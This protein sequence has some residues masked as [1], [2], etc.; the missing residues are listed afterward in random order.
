MKRFYKDVSIDERDGVWRV[1]LDGRVLKTQGKASVELPNRALA[2]AVATEWAAQDENIDPPNMFLTRLAFAAIDGVKANRQRVA[3]HALSFGRTDLLCY[4]AEQPEEL[5]AR[6]AA[7]WNPLLDWVAERYGVRL[8]VATGIAF[9]EQS[10]EAL[11]ALERAIAGTDDFTL[12]AL[13]T[14]ATITGSLVLALALIEEHIDAE[15]AFAAATLDET[16]QSEKWGLDT[17]AQ[18]RLNRLSAELS[19]A[20]QFAAFLP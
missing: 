8:S 1:L 14:A 12:A 20:E 9:T 11:V 4:R 18:T 10:P 5:V 16:F 13:H 6:Q 7:V 3:E 15:Q 2:D 19:A 17:E